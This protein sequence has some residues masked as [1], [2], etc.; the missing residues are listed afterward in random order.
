M[1]AKE[2]YKTMWNPIYEGTT[3]KQFSYVEMIEFAEEYAKN[4]K[5]KDDPTAC[6]HPNCFEGTVPNYHN[7]R[8]SPC[9]VCAKK[10]ET[11][12]TSDQ[13]SKELKMDVKVL[14]PDGWDRQNYEYSYYQELITEQEYRLRV[15]MST[16][17]YSPCPVCAKKG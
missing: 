14:D 11:K 13:W 1:T 15:V 8:Y 16:V 10:T 3:F 12:K 4:Q 5:P 6:S 7:T 9:P 2:F 17:E